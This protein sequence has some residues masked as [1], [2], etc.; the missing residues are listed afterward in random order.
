MIPKLK[1]SLAQL[2]RAR[3]FKHIQ[4]AVGAGL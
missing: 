4:D 3:G 2:L 1:A